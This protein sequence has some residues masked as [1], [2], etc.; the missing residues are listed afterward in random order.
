MVSIII[1]AVKLNDYFKEC[2]SS[3][4]TQTYEDIEILLVTEKGTEDEVLCYEMARKDPRIRVIVKEKHNVGKGRNYGLSEAK[5]EY[6]CFVDADDTF[7][8]ET[9]LER[10]LLSLMAE[11]GDVLVSNYVR[12][13]EDE[14]IPVVNHG[15][16]EKDDVLSE[17]FRFKGFFS[18]AHLSFVWAKLYRKEFLDDHEIVFPETTNGEDRAFNMCVYSARPDY[19][20]SDQVTYVYRNNLDSITHSYHE[21]FKE[22]WEGNAVFYERY[23]EGKNEKYYFGDLP[24]FVMMFSLIFH[25]RQEYEKKTSKKDILEVVEAYTTDDYVQKKMS[26]LVDHKICNQIS[27]LGYRAGTDNLSKWIVKRRNDSIIFGL[28]KIFDLSIDKKH[29]PETRN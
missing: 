27:D 15:F 26:Y 19:V 22:I 21:K 2:I 10:M 17:D 8:N 29:S 9:S 12:K 1:C 6:I 28:E 4:V 20:F 23:M 11:K 3:C 25:V 7:Y 24:A 5:G 13:V 18:Q 16:S 14:M